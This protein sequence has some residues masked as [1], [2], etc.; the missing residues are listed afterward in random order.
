MP[1]TNIYRFN[2]AG[3][4]EFSKFIHD[5]RKIEAAGG[6]KLKFPSIATD[7]SLIELVSSTSSIDSDKLFSNRYEMA[8]YLISAW[9]DFSDD[10]YDDAGVWAWFAAL[11]FNQL[12]ANKRRTQ[13]QEHFI[14]DRY[15]P[16]SLSTNLDYRHSVSLPFFLKSNYED[17]FCKFILTGRPLYE[18]GDPC[19]NCCGNKKLM[20]SKTMRNLMCEL[21]L[22]KTKMSVK[23]GAFTKPSKNNRKSTAGRGGAQRLIPIIIPRLKKSY[24]VEDMPVDEIILASGTEILNSKWI[25]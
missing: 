18:L 3:L 8:E 21:Y 25:K 16:A 1:I 11:Y 15:A 20:S 13:R 10:Q 24:D 6:M 12:R 9:K 14:P 17:D 19:E 2:E 23:S 4:K 22:D 7:A 5:T